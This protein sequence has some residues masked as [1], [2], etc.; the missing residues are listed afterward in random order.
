M[1]TNIL[2]FGGSFNPIH[3]GHLI[4]ARIMKENIGA[5]QV[6]FMPNGNPPNKE[7]KISALDKLGMVAKAISDDNDFFFDDYELKKETPSYTLETIKY[8]KKKYWIEEPHWIIGPDNLEDLK[9]WHK[10]DELVE[11]CVFV[12]GCNHEDTFNI[13]SCDFPPHAKWYNLPQ[14]KDSPFY[15]KMKLKVI[16]IPFID[17]RSTEVRKRLS[18]GLSVRHMIPDEVEKYIREYGLYYG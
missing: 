4:I 6:I 1:E 14:F 11:E 15:K 7:E 18:S 17:I 3:N 8:I 13:L 9:N 10:I 16:K 5:D 2:F 12:M